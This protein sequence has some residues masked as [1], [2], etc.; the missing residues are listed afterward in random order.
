MAA[1][2]NPVATVTV[3]LLVPPRGLVDG[4]TVQVAWAGRP[5]QVNAALLGSAIADVR[6]SAYVTVCPEVV[7]R[8]AGP[9]DAR[10]KSIPVP[11]RMTD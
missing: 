9:F 8:L 5:A 7:D 11:V 6:K 10:V 2:D 4:L 1:L 3:M